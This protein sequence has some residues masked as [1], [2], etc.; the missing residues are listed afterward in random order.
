MFRITLAALAAVVLVGASLMP[1]DAFARRGGGGGYRGG[2]AITEVP[3][4]SG[5][6]GRLRAERLASAAV[7]T[8]LP[9]GDTQDAGRYGYRY[10]RPVA[11]AAERRRSAP[12]QPEPTATTAATITMAAIRM[13]TAIRSARSNIPIDRTRSMRAALSKACRRPCH[14]AAAASQ[15]LPGTIYRRIEYE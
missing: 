5:R 7:V 10:R 14:S 6:S 4:T 13:V 1:D 9:V 15:T 8:A 11:R 2:E 3:P 12:R